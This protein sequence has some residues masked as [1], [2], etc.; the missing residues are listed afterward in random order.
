MFGIC[1]VKDWITIAEYADISELLQINNIFMLEDYLVLQ[2]T[3]EAVDDFFL[4]MHNELREF[5]SSKV[6][7]SV[8][9]RLIY[10]D[11]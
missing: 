9:L 2:N 7:L 5:Q 1:D 3:S 11:P 10:S 4:F 6:S 8:E